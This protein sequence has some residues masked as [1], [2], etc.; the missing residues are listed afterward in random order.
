M[1]D[2][3]IY[4]LF[5]WH[6]IKKFMKDTKF[7]VFFFYLAYNKKINEGYQIQGILVFGI[8]YLVAKTFLLHVKIFTFHLKH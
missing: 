2:L 1:L 5:T 6:V 8:S 4:Y 7:K 3:L